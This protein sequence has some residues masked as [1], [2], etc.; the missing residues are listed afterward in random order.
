MATDNPDAVVFIIGTN[1]ASDRQRLRLRTTTACPTGKPTYRMKIDRMMDHVRGRLAPSHRVL[2]RAADAR[3]RDASTRAPRRSAR[4]CA[5]KRRSSRPTS[6]YVDTYQLF[7]DPN[8]EYSRDLPDANGNV[9]HRCASPTGSTSPSTAR[10]YLADAVLKLLDA[11]WHITQ[12]GRSRGPDRL[13]HRRRQRRATCPASGAT[14]VAAR[15]FVSRGPVRGVRARGPAS[16]TTALD[17][18]TRRRRSHVA[19]HGRVDRPHRTATPPTSTTAH[20]DTAPP[21]RRARRR[22][23]DDA[24]GHDAADA[25]GRRGRGRY[26]ARMS[27]DLETRG[28][29]RGR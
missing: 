2:A 15:A 5:R 7:A 11:R 21:T 22:R 13:H 4:S 12:A 8:G 18:R 9:D 20:A 23:L 19:D 1:D 24:T 27:T 28:R 14:A 25:C 26:R 3:R 29:R 17:R 6:S 10:E 16:T